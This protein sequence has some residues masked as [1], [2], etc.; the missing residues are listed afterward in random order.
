MQIA[1]LL[2][3][4][5]QEESNSPLS[6][7]CP[8]SQSDSP[9]PTVVSTTAYAK[10]ATDSSND[11]LNKPPLLYVTH[12]KFELTYARDLSEPTDGVP[13]YDSETNNWVIKLV[14]IFLSFLSNIVD[15]QEQGFSLE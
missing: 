5:P 7:H 11:Q 10:P 9:L 1:A 13:E 2:Q 12:F 15:H 3:N 8:S 6:I 4:E 14:Y